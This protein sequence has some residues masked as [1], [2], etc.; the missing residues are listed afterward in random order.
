LIRGGS[1]IALVG[2]CLI[3]PVVAAIPTAEATL[4][5]GVPVS[6]VTSADG[7]ASRAFTLRFTRPGAPRAPDTGSAVLTLDT[8]TAELSGTERLVS[9][10]GSLTLRWD[11]GAREPAAAAAI[12]GFWSIADGRGV[13]SG[14][15]GR[16]RF[17][18]DRALR[19]VVYRGLVVTAV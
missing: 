5:K 17:T 12:A 11:A 10:R 7:C 18:S 9:R 15:H 19:A 13:Y 4:V 8:R 2:V 6:I 16:G 14:L 3:A 1:S